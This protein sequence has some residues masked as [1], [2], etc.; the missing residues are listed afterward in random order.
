MVVGLHATLQVTPWG[1]EWLYFYLG[2]AGV[3]IFFPI[4]G[5]VMVVSTQGRV[6]SAATSTRFALAR[7][8]RIAPIY[9][10][11]TLAKAGAAAVRPALFPQYQFSLEG[12]AAAL[13]F[14][15]YYDVSG[16]FI[17]PPLKVGWTLNLEM[18][19]Y[20]LIVVVLMF[21]RRIALHVPL[22]IV[23]IVILTKLAAPHLPFFAVGW[24][25]PLA[26]EFAA[27]MLIGQTTLST[28]WSGRLKWL[29]LAAGLLIYALVPDERWGRVI[30]WGVPGA[31]FLWAAVGFEKNIAGRAGVVGFLALLGDASYSLYLT[32]SISLPAL[33]APIRVLTPSSLDPAGLVALLALLIAVSTTI[34]IGF[35]L[36]VEKP[37]TQGLKRAMRSPG[38]GKKVSLPV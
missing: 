12:L 29:A 20:A 2:N 36:L 4:S 6:A 7:V 5:F 34:G 8:I 28:S 18:F 15:P 1:G 27:G 23:G 33:A 19:Y 21:S 32:H 13:L 31:L 26:L 10:L 30:C 17:S 35:H 11:L 38:A 3:D 22:L 25:E 24:G 16:A 37:L 14:I 9:Y